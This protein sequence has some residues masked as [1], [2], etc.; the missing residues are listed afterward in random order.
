[1]TSDAG[2]GRLLGVRAAAR[3]L[4]V[5]PSTVSRYLKDHPELNHNSA[6][7]PMVDLEELRQHR[8]ENLSAARRGS[9]AGRLIGKSDGSNGANGCGHPGTKSAD[10]PSYAASKAARESVL[11]YRARVDLDAKLGLLVSRDEVEAAAEEAA[12]MLQRDLLELPPRLAEEIVAKDNPEEIRL[13]LEFHTFAPCSRITA[14]RWEA[15][16]RSKQGPAQGPPGRALG[17][18]GFGVAWEARSRSERRGYCKPA[19]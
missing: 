1:M 13:R 10:I 18:G 15:G 2:A 16:A 9:Y 5:N 3:A 12:Q 7:R 17:S 6:A 4:E 14:P 11:A 8:V 19:L